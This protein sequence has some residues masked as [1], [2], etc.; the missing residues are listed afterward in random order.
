MAET[1]YAL[2][3]SK[4]TKLYGTA[5]GVENVTLKVPKG[6]VYGFLGPN[7]SGKSTTINMIVNLLKPTTG[8]IKALG[9]D[10]QQDSLRILQ[11]TGFL[12]GDMALDRGLT[13]WQQLE[14]YGNL[15]GN[16]D[17]KYVRELAARLDCKLQK[18]F[19]T[20]SRGNKQKVGLIAALMHKP[21]LLIL[22][23]PTSG[24][25]P[26]I[27]AEFNKIILEQKAKGVTTFISSH[28][29]SE[30]QE[31]CDY[32]A[33]IRQGRI[34]ANKS[35]NEI[36]NSTHRLVKI[37]GAKQLL[38]KQLKSLKNATNLLHS[39][40]S[41]SFNYD[42]DI[43]SLLALLSKQTLQDVIITEPN[44]D[45]VFMKLYEGGHA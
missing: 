43:N 22:D 44:L 7:G 6:S 15:R 40:E 39:E 20:L 29:L 19:K 3:L 13:G 31:L 34:V 25:D 8:T 21:D 16:F 41:I 10:S 27:Q 1:T 23:E 26:L 12:A 14:Y 17:K 30:I 11:R 33:F 38:L 28:V 32:A 5:V 9:L 2:E 24:L 37:R 45:D 18:K 36:M 35:M 4:V 42:G